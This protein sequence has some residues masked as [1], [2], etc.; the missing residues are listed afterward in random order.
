M[1]KSDEE[2]LKVINRQLSVFGSDE[3]CSYH[4]HIIPLTKLIMRRNSTNANI[5]FIYLDRD[6][7]QLDSTDYPIMTINN[8]EKLF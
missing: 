4:K 5:D 6:E 7:Y 8:L 3:P 2:F 1:N